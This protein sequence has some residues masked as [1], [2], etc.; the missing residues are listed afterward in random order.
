LYPHK[1]YCVSFSFSLC[2]SIRP[3]RT[4]EHTNVYLLF[5]DRL[6]QV[7]YDVNVTGTKNLLEAAKEAGVKKFVFTSSARFVGFLDALLLLPTE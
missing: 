3:S 1:D 6:E 7:Q 4:N 2:I 5:F